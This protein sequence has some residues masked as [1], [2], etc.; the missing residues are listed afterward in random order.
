LKS[1]LNLNFPSKGTVK[2]MYLG[3]SKLS[4]LK[5]KNEFSP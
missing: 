4:F 3:I 1:I 2:S 5:P